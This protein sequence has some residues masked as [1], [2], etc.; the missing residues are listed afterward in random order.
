LAALPRAGPAPAIGWLL[1][2]TA[3]VAVPRVTGNP[4]Y[5]QTATVA[6]IYVVLAVAYDL[7]VGRIGALSLCQPVFFAWGSYAAAL[8]ATRGGNP[9]FWVEALVAM[10]GAVAL[11]IAIGVPSFRL[12]L[13][14][15][16][17]GTLG[18]LLI[19]QLVAV[20][21]ISVTGG[22]LCVVGVPAL[23]VP[24]GGLRL[25]VLSDTQNYYTILAIAVLTVAAIGLLI[26]SRTGAALT[27]TRDDPVLAAARGI[28]PLRMRLTA[29]SVSAAFSGLAGVFAA[30]FQ[31]VVCASQ[32]D[33]PINTLLLVM[34][35]IGGRASLRGVVTGAVLFTVLPQVL[36]VADAWRLVI[37][38]VMLL[39]MVTTVPDGIEHVYAGAP[40]LVR[41]LLARMDRSAHHRAQDG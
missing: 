15:F 22:P 26:R 1:A 29:F 13:H 18:F 37:F 12:S 21:W 6:M 23:A 31:H 24:L 25:T 9:G 35:F 28:W 27:A 20:N 36:R 8:L 11:A 38:G 4:F 2:A 3:A 41:R 14:S 30:H 10:A 32:V 17:I 33:I 7:V 40:G 39:V 19:A 34:V 5:L 16:A